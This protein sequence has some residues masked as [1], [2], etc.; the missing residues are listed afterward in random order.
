MDE[1]NRDRLLKNLFLGCK[2]LAE[3]PDSAPGLV[4]F[5]SLLDGT[6]AKR[7]KRGELLLESIPRF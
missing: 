6:G 2:P 4:C 5:F 1:F 7:F 3:K